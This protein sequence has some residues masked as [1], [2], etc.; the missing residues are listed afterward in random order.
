M[1]DENRSEPPQS[2]LLKFLSQILSARGF[3]LGTAAILTAAASW[4]KAPD[5]TA[6]KATYE[7]LVARI[8]ELSRDTEANH[9][10]LQAFIIAYIGFTKGEVPQSTASAASS[11]PQLPLVGPQLVPLIRKKKSPEPYYT[12]PP[13][14]QPT[15]ENVVVRKP[16]AQSDGVKDPIGVRVLADVAPSLTPRETPAALP[17]FDQVVQQ[18]SKK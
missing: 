18:A 2:K 16:E 15:L 6:T 10:D 12:K 7:V 8:N 17:P 11:G 1:A 14:T 13:S 5:T 3:I 9:N 4:F